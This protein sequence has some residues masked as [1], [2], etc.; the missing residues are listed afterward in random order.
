MSSCIVNEVLAIAYIITCCNIITSRSSMLFDYL[1]AKFQQGN[2]C[3]LQFA[4]IRTFSD[5]THLYPLFISQIYLH[6][7][8]TIIKKAMGSLQTDN[9]EFQTTAREL[10]ANGAS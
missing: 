8:V 1:G 3:T 5:M 4:Q 10:G 7:S 2:N 9:S 6:T